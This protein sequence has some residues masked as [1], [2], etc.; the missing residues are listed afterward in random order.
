M[1][2]FRPASRTWLIWGTHW[3]ASATRFKRS[4]TLPP[5]EMKSLYA[6]IT[7]SAV[8]SRSYVTGAMVGGS[9]AWLEQ[10]V[11][12]LE[13]RGILSAD[14]RV[15]AAWVRS[16]QGSAHGARQR[17]RRAPV[18]QF[19]DEVPLGPGCDMT[20]QAIPPESVDDIR[21]ASFPDL[22]PVLRYVEL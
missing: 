12:L 22:G 1:P 15:L 2:A 8:M 17:D 7:T 19:A 18:V 6:S 5:S 10:L 14:R 16:L 13:R 3:F 4:H 21:E 20:S 11:Q 9:S